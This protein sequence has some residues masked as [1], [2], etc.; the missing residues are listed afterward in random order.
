[1]SKAMTLRLD[2]QLAEDLT[3]VA[4]LDGLSRAETARQALR[5]YLD[6]RLADDATRGQL[7]RAHEAERRRLECL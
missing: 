4:R 1:M 5:Q 3:L 6:S 2:D 7:E